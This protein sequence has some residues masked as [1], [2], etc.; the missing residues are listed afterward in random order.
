[1]ERVERSQ[2]SF[3]IN[4]PLRDLTYCSLNFELHFK[5]MASH[6]VMAYLVKGFKRG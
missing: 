2:C 3:V 4:D 1:M 5:K 6:R